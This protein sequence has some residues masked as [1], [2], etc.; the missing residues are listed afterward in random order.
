M[1]K[2]TGVSEEQNT[3]LSDRHQELC[4]K[5][6]SRIMMIRMTNMEGESQTTLSYS[7]M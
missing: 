7:Q 1:L 3:A 4:D 2:K 5:V 6:R